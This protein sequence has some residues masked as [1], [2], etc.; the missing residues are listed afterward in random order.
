MNL[1][2]MYSDTVEQISTRTVLEAESRK[3]LALVSVRL[4]ASSRQAFVGERIV[5]FAHPVCLDFY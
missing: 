4:I 2:N 5:P 3:E 1:G